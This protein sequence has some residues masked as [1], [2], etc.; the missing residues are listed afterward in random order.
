MAATITREQVRIFAPAPPQPAFSALRGQFS[1]SKTYYHLTVAAGLH[2][3]VT[4][5]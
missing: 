1:H 5:F 3:H 4:L 2:L